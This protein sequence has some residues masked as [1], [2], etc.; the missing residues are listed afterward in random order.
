MVSFFSSLALLFEQQ[1]LLRAI[2]VF[3]LLLSLFERPI[4]I[5]LLCFSRHCFFVK[6]NFLKVLQEKQVEVGDALSQVTFS[7]AFLFE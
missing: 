5:L 1:F 6:G 7:R 2:S 3:F 4:L